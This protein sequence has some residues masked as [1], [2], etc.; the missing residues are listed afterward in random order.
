[1]KF[2]RFNLTV[3]FLVALCFLVALFRA[4]E[5]LPFPMLMGER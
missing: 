1:M 5:I 3:A 2:T 4:A